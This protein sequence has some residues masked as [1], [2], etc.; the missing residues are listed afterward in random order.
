MQVS[1][2]VLL[3]TGA[4]DQPATKRALT[5]SL[6]SWSHRQLAT[7]LGTIA[8][9]K[10]KNLRSSPGGLFRNEEQKTPLLSSS[11]HIKWHQAAAFTVRVARGAALLRAAKGAIIRTRRF[12]SP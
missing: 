12:K 4:A 1:R 9:E 11:V 3:L 10:K 5:A 8:Q 6:G 2:D 7:S